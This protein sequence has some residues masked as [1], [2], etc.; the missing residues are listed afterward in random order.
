MG[1]GQEQKE[2][3]LRVYLSPCPLL[4]RA[5]LPL[6]VGRDR[7]RLGDRTCSDHTATP[8]WTG[9]GWPLLRVL[10]CPVHICVH[11]HQSICSYLYY[12]A[13]SLC[14]SLFPS[15]FPPPPISLFSADS[16]LDLSVPL[17]RSLSL[18]LTL[19]VSLSLS[20]VSFSV[21]LSLLLCP[22]LYVSLCHSVSAS[23][24]SL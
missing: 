22:C 4:S 3:R 23:L 13:R 14:L 15:V 6:P 17:L 9:S 18:S 16:G 5:P 1:T 10:A 12:C 11:L 2:P 7:L 20:L 19:F 8:A 21:T 24:L